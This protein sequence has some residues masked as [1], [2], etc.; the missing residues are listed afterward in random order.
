MFV[1]RKRRIFIVTL[2]I[3]YGSF[4]FYCSK[5]EDQET[6]LILPGCHIFQPANN[7][8]VQVGEAVDFYCGYTIGSFPITE[9]ILNFGDSTASWDSAAISQ[10]DPRNPII[11]LK[12][13]YQ[14]TGAYMI[15]LYLYDRR[16]GAMAASTV[17]V[18]NS[19]NYD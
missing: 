2:I 8:T 4:C 12:H 9:I 16:N 3:F 5:D 19:A 10:F 1:Q 11:K 18:R 17:V 13:V 14:D 6:T 7:D 15:Q